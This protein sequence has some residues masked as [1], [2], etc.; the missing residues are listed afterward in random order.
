MPSESKDEHD[1]GMCVLVITAMGLYIATWIMREKQKQCQQRVSRYRASVGVPKKPASRTAELDRVPD[2]PDF[3]LQIAPPKDFM[4]RR[5][6]CD[7]KVR[8]TSYS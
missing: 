2:N 8:G 1:R 6:C 4:I 3:S 5:I 7:V